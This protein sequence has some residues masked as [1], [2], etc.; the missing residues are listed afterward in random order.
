MTQL[1]IVQV[2]VPV[3]LRRE[4]DFLLP[5]GHDR[6]PV[7][8]VRVLVPFGHRRLVGIVTGIVS[9]GQVPAYSLKR[10]VSV[11]DGEPILPAKLVNLVRWAADYYQQPIGIAWQTALPQLLR[12]KHSLTPNIPEHFVLTD[13]GMHCDESLDRARVQR[14]IMDAFAA[15]PGYCLDAPALKLIS[16]HWRQPV[17]ALMRRDWVRRTPYT[18]PPASGSQ[19]RDFSLNEDQQE[20]VDAIESTVNFR[21]FLLY[22]ITGSGKTEVYLESIRTVV[23]A[24]KQALVL[25]PEISLTPQLV[26][27]LRQRF[28]KSVAV[29]HSGLAAGER[30]YNW[31]RAREGHAPVVLG[32][33][34]AVFAPLQRPGLI[35]VDEEHDTSYKQQD[36][37]RYHARDV[38][39]YRAKLE[40]VPVVLGSATPSLESMYNTSVARYRRLTLTERAKDSALPRIGYIDMRR[41]A[42]QDGVSTILFQA[43]EQR[44]ERSEQSLIFINRR[45]Y[46]P[47]WCCYGCGW[48]AQCERCDAHLTLHQRINKLLCHHCGREQPPQSVCPQCEGVSLGPLGAGTQRLEDGLGKRLPQ[49]RIVRIDRDSTRHKGSLENSLTAARNR[50]VDILVGTQLLT[51]GHDFPYVTLVGV[52]NADQGLYSVDYRATEQLFQQLLQVSG[53]A[54]RDIRAGE[55]LIQTMYPDHPVFREL[56]NHDYTRFAD[57]ALSERKSA[58]YPPYSRFALLRA[59]STRASAALEFLQAARRQLRKHPEHRRIH[60]MDAV[61][62]P[63]EKRAGRYRAQLLLSAPDRSALHDALMPWLDWMETWPRSRTVRWSIDI[64]PVDMY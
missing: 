19:P 48:H 29:L 37:M 40:D 18:E 64:D 51:K 8:G 27:A 36:G 53:R 14:R 56:A 24:G 62:A 5:E 34:S 57:Y 63:M 39:V 44:L 58:D 42:A 11:L 25:V 10:I 52:I 21:A 45:G 31:W 46:A 47:V 7:P 35:I 38:A 61:R 60:V 23:N 32:T 17:D 41:T 20:A 49:A 4:F 55:V 54:G 9:T 22:G 6:S 15:A 28:G 33:R 2:A 30:H 12:G 16:R 3:P 1:S 13:A 50:E 26:Q 43:L 59:E